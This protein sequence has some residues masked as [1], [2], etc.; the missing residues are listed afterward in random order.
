VRLHT[1]NSHFTCIMALLNIDHHE[2]TPLFVLQFN[3]ISCSASTVTSRSIDGSVFFDIRKNRYKRHATKF[4]LCNSVSILSAYTLKCAKH[5]MKRLDHPIYSIT[6]NYGARDSVVGWSN[7]L[8][9]WRSR[10]RVPMKW[11]FCL[12][13]PSSRIMALGRLIL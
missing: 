4:N 5:K 8:Q 13:N 6:A 10:I 12:P 11:I 7:I 3:F 1:F 2:C 9:A